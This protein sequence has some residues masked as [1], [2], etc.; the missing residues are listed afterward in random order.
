VQADSPPLTPEELAA[1]V[2]L[3]DSEE[4]RRTSIIGIMERAQAV[5]GVATFADFKARALRRSPREWR[6]RWW[7][8]WC[9][10]HAP[11]ISEIPHFR[12]CKI[13]RRRD[14]LKGQA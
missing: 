14:K 4:E 3:L 13:G 9:G 7:C 2:R 6:C 11:T 10:A 8:R 12:W 1:L 5:N